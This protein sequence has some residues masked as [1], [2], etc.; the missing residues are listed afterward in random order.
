MDLRVC[1]L[2]TAGLTF[3]LAAGT[4]S[5]YFAAEVALNG[6]FIF[7]AICL[8]VDLAGELVI[9]F[10]F[11]EALPF[12]CLAVAGAFLAFACFAAGAFDKLFPLAPFF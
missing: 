2:G 10:S 4:A 5:P 11:A 6:D 12:V 8:L 3:K 1:Y 7:W 9:S